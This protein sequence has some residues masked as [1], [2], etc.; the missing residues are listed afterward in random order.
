MTGHAKTV[1]WLG[2]IMIAFGVILRWSEIKAVVFGT[3][4]ILGRSLD[5]GIQRAEKQT[6]KR[7]VTGTVTGSRL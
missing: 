4:G 2:L 7:S 5:P 1:L 3:G 6:A